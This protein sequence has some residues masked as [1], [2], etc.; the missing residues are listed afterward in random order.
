MKKVLSLILVAIMVLTCAATM[1]SCQKDTPAADN[2]TTT[3]DNQTTTPDNTEAQKSVGFV[4][5]GLGGEFFQTLADTYKAKYESLGWK[6]SYADGEFNPVKQVEACENYIAQGVDLLYIWAVDA[7]SVKTVVHDARERGIKVVAFV[8][9]LEEYDA[10]MVSEDA[11]L[12]DDADRLAAKWI[13]EHFADAED[14]SVEVAVFSCR[15]ADTGV[16]QADEL[17]KIESFSQK[18][19]LVMEVECADETMATGQSK[20]ENLYTTNPELKVFLT[21]HNGLA[22]GI[23]SFFTAQSSPV[24]DYTDLGVFAINGDATSA[25]LIK[26]SI[27]GS[28]PFRGMVLTGSV[29]DT[30]NEMVMVGTGLFDGS[31]QVGHIQK[32]GTIFVDASTV[33]EYITT[34]TVVSK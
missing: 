2:T 7:A 9:P 3:P 8:C 34:G 17:L 4:T 24:T 19:K 22:L 16:I 33:D 12:A 20:M 30:A 14:H 15:A 13:D 28:T 26:A 23:N 21:A 10:L 11:E 25:E 6:A 32:A 1:M 27:D 31:I 5:F 18:A 29:D